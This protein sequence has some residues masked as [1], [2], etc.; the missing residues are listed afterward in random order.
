MPGGEPKAPRRMTTSETLS[1]HDA[2]KLALLSQW[3]PGARRAGGSALDASLA[4]LRHLGYIQID[5]ISVIER[6]HHHT[7]WNRAPRYRQAHFDEL[8][9][10]RKIFEYWSHAAACLPMEDF[11]FAL[12]RMRAYAAG[13]LR[14]WHSPDPKLKRRALRRIRAEGPL[15]ARDF[16]SPH[17][18]SAA[19]TAAWWEHRP[20][21]QALEQLF[22]EGKLMVAGRRG[23]HKVYDLAERVLPPR[24]DTSAPTPREYAEFLVRRFLRANGLGAPAE[25]AYLRPG[26]KKTAEECMARMA[27][28]GELLQVRVRDFLYYAL[29][30]SLALL[31]ERLPRKRVKILSPFDNLLIQRERMRRLFDFDY[32]IECYTPA[33]KRKHGYFSLPIL[34]GGRLVARMDCKAERRARVFVIRN[35]SGE[36]HFARAGA[37]RREEFAAALAAE[38][39]R[40]A[41]F[42]QCGRVA[43]EKLRDTAMRALLRE[44]LAA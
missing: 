28:R 12:P 25:V 5:T 40:F 14:H 33:R 11:R 6:A 18:K 15:R 30:E 39:T 9:R 42:H 16:A 21:K 44:A 3:P 27:R 2:R 7:W 41:A 35:F 24:T 4:A 38:V 1:I 23:F 26:A 13:R 32:Q 20:A 8:L 43:V 29:P 31:R 22:M 34:W 10:A 19:K 37:S 17:E 36:P